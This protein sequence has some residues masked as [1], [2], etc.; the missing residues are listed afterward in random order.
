VKNSSI[1]FLVA[2]LVLVWFGAEVYTA[3]NICVTSC[4]DLSGLTGWEQAIAV[5][6]LP[7]LL[8]AGG[9]KARQNEKKQSSTAVAE[10]TSS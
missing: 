9:V 3:Q 10:S 4:I 7:A 1:L 6:I 2:F 8:I 5:A